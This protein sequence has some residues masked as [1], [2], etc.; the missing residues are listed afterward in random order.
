MAP[1][2]FAIATSVQDPLIAEQLVEAL[3]EKELD[4]FSRAGGAA[5]AGFEP[6]SPAFWDIFV[7]TES[8]EKAQGIITGLLEDLEKNAEENARAAEEEA[9]SGETPVGE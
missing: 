4:A 8:F 5:S 3:R 7:P 6:A 2:T 9:L 1:R